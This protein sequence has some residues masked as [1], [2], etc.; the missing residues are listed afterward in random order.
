[1]SDGIRMQDTFQQPPASFHETG[2]IPQNTMQQIM[3][4][5]NRTQQQQQQF[6][7]YTI[8][9]RKEPS[10]PSYVPVPKD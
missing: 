6:S 8:P 3:Q 5:S 10:V 9:T 7:E 2:G 4:Q 1:M